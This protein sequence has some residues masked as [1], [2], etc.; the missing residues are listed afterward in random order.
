MV[1]IARRGSNLCLFE[2]EKI[3]DYPVD[4]HAPED[5]QTRGLKPPI[6]LPNSV[7]QIVKVF[8]I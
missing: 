4:L 6:F 1:L 8:G 7:T 3:K 5:D 2:R